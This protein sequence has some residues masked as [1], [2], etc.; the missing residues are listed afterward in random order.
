MNYYAEMEH[1][2]KEAAQLVKQ[3]PLRIWLRRS[4][5]QAENK[6]LKGE[7]RRL[8]SKMAQEAAG[9]YPGSR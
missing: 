7:V 5:L 2:P 6:A 8:K 3:L 4:H 9:R 1:L